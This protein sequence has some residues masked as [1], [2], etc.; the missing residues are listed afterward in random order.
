M[1]KVPSRVAESGASGLGVAPSSDPVY[2]AIMR[3]GVT[4][5]LFGVLWAVLQFA[6]PA[7]ALVADARLERASL[8]AAG[9]HVE[10]GSSERCPPVHRDACALCQV[11]SRIPRPAETPELPAIAEVLHRSA[12]SPIARHAARPALAASLP[13]APPSIA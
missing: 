2:V 12:E 1:D 7:V 8:K 13:R 4:W 5:R 9:S 6:L 10:A 3:R 11:V